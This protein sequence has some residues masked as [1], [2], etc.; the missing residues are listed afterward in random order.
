MKTQTLEEI[1]ISYDG[2]VF[3]KTM[4]KNSHKFIDDGVIDI[5][6]PFLKVCKCGLL[7]KDK[8]HNLLKEK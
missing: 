4:Q 1:L 7:Q 5:Y 3:N 2:R 8:I 6:N